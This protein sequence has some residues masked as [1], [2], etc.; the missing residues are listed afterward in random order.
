MEKSKI[1]EG[2][3]DDQ[4]RSQAPVAPTQEIS[5]TVKDWVV[6]IRRKREAEMENSKNELF[7]PP[8][9]CRRPDV[10]L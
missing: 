7:P 2:K 4:K 1:K 9:E 10:T 3:E 8:I 6:E 5:A